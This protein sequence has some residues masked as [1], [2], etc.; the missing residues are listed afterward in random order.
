MNGSDVHQDKEQ[1][2]D[3]AKSERESEH[4]RLAAQKI[5]DALA[6]L[7]EGASKTA[8][9]D[10]C[11]VHHRRLSK[12]FASLLDEGVIVECEVLTGNHKTPKVGYR[13]KTDEDSHDA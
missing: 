13:L 1:R 5:L 4:D 11:G 6:K 9:R 12:V 3:D 2:Q 7:P 10:R 8:I